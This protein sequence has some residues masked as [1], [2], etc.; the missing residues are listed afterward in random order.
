MAGVDVLSRIMNGV[1]SGGGL[2]GIVGSVADGGMAR[3]GVG[4]VP[5]G[6]RGGHTMALATLV[7]VLTH[8]RG[9]AQGLQALVDTLHHA[10][11]TRQVNSWIDRGPNLAAQPEELRRAFSAEVLNA[12]SRETGLRE[13]E[14]L[15]GLARGLPA[16]IEKLCPLGR[17]P[18]SDAEFPE[19]PE[20]DLLDELRRGAAAAKNEA[21]GRDQRSA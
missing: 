20:D 5:T 8:G 12:V 14:L 10:G 17:L 9:G 4:G 13:H 6:E 21:E 2:G 7:V 18:R 15:A 19:M 3:G 16:F 1:L 11:L